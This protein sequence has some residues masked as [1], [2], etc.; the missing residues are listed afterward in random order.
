MKKYYLLL[1]PL[2]LLVLTGC[3]SGEKKTQTIC[4]GSLTDDEYSIDMYYTINHDSKYINEL[5]IS[6]LYTIEDPSL[7]DEYLASVKETYEGESE[8]YGGY[9]INI[10]VV[11]GITGD[12]QIEAKVLIDYTKLDVKKLKAD[13]EFM[14][15]LFVGDKLSLDKVVNYYENAGLSCE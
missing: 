13:N 6:E 8:L 11:K 7:I 14:K 2:L 9:T 10:S 4:E 15:S 5:F 12:D 1:I 3:D